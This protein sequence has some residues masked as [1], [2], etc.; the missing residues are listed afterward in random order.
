MMMRGR[1]K[2]AGDS[3]AI[4]SLKVLNPKSYEDRLNEVFDLLT[5][6]WLNKS[7]KNK[8]FKS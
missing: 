5:K 4:Q 3:L 8:N 7:T 6:V 1:S 2:K